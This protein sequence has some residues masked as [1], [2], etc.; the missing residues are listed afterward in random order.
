MILQGNGL[1]LGFYEGS[2]L[3]VVRGLGVHD[4][5][6]VVTRALRVLH[7][8]WDRFSKAACRA[9]VKVFSGFW[10]R[11]IG[12]RV[13]KFVFTRDSGVEGSWRKD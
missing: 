2:I 8:F 11:N 7:R 10:L 4:K 13:S 3:Q 1:R 12:S 6:S 9:L 5:G